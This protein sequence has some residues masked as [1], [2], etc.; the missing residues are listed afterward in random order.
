MSFSLFSDPDMLNLLTLSTRCVD[1]DCGVCRD[2]DE[3][4]MGDREML[5]VLL[6]LPLG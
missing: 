4:L 3:L 6:E 1:L 2:K 5:R